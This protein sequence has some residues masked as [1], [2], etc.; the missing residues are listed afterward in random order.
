MGFGMG[1]GMI[2]IGR[3]PLT[4][5]MDLVGIGRI[6]TTETIGFGF[7]ITNPPLRNALRVWSILAE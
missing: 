7:I 3:I 1:F 6:P 2:G 4:G 5:I